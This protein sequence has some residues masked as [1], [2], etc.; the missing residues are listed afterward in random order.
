MVSF[1]LKSILE[2]Y[3]FIKLT[4]C[5]VILELV[6]PLLTAVEIVLQEAIKTIIKG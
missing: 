1:D 6:F 5:S 2:V 3:E 4:L